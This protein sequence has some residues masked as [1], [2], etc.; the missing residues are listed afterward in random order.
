MPQGARIS[1]AVGRSNGTRSSTRDPRWTDSRLM[2]R[3][4]R[5]GE[6]LAPSLARRPDSVYKGPIPAT[7]TVRGKSRDQQN[8][9]YCRKV[10]TAA[11]R[12]GEEPRRPARG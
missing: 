11:T 8:G 12:P 2:D 7:T 6:P 4:S 5:L 1:L 9:H 10:V 3:R